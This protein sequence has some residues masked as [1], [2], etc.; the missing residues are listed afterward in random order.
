M[1]QGCKLDYCLKCA[2][3]KPQLFEHL[4]QGEMEDFL[5]S[6][7]SCKSTFPSLDNITRYLKESLD[8]NDSR[9]NK[10]EDRMGK[11]ENNQKAT[12]TAM[13]NMKHEIC[14]SLKD[15]VNK[16]VD[17]RNNELDDRRRRECNIALFNLPEHNLPTGQDNKT[18]DGEDFKQL[19]LCLGLELP[20]MVTWFRLGKKAPDRIRPLKIVLESKSQRKAI[21]DNAKFI[22]QKAPLSLKNVIIS[23]DLTPTQRQERKLRRQRN[24]QP[25]PDPGNGNNSASPNRQPSQEGS[26]SDRNSPAAMNTSLGISP[27][28]T[29]P[30]INFSSFSQSRINEDAYNNTT[31][32]MDET[33][34]GG[35]SSQQDLANDSIG[36]I[37]SVGDEA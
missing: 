15:D 6:C 5:W 8:K 9:M 30:H 27:I 32:A 21:L 7:R 22:P 16:L 20:N 19:C 26:N 28:H 13:T 31:I 18:A 37:P 35:F 23:K 11:L 1:C 12:T 17:A 10:L 34:I 4:T 25:R 24:N 29:M 36:L 3:I 33:V 2:G 14:Q